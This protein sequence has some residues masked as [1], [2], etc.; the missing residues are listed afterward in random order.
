MVK[1]VKNYTEDEFKLYLDNLYQKTNDARLIDPKTRSRIFKRMD[2]ACEITGL[3]F[4]DL[5]QRLDF[6][7]RDLT[8]EALEAFF[9]ELRSIF[10]L[11]KFGFTTIAPQQAKN[12]TQPDFRA[13]YGEKESVIEVFCL[14]KEHEQERD[15][16]TGP[17]R[18][19]D[20][21][22]EGSKFRRDFFTK[23]KIKKKQLDSINSEIKI[24]LCAINSTQ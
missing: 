7:P 4:P 12:N 5:L 21:E 11:K 16:V 22:F 3:S 24:L 13:K 2:E 8:I 17:Y 14:T 19:F 15:I 10:W 9:A 18:D 20:P 6:K 23:A 1:K